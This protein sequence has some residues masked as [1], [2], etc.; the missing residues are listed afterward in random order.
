[1]NYEVLINA[2]ADVNAII[3]GERS[4]LGFACNIA[5]C[6]AP[7]EFLL[8]CGADPLLPAYEGETALHVAAAGGHLNKCRLL[9]EADQHTLEMRDWDGRNPLCAAVL[10]GH[11]KIVQLFESSGA[12]MHTRD[13]E[14]NTLLH[15]ASDCPDTLAVLL[16]LLLTTGLRPN[17]SDN[18]GETP[19]HVAA[20]AGNKAAV[21]LLLRYGADP[22]AVANDGFTTVLLTAVKSGRA[23]V[24]RLLL[25]SGLGPEA[26]AASKTHKEGITPLMVACAKNNP[27]V[28]RLLLERGRCQRRPQ[29]RLCA[30]Y[31]CV[32][33]QRGRGEAVHGAAARGWC[34][35]ARSDSRGHN[36][37]A[38]CCREQV[39]ACAAVAARAR[40]RCCR[41][42]R[43]LICAVQLLRPDDAAD[44]VPARRAR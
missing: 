21:Q 42:H 29:R 3:M 19:L 36:S 39:A 8:K 38:Y 13:N 25:D 23:D 20:S 4:A 31:S 22:A 27:A 37:V 14:G 6:D 41:S 43:R 28:T 12:D 30:V 32:D 11:P 16:H 33:G 26:L 35:R 34:R 5:C 40:Q 1:V 7:L 15:F 9:I 2:G 10:A 44:A 17:V 24:V 18:Q